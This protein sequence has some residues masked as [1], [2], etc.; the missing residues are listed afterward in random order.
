M[1]GS[2]ASSC[3]VRSS[4][5]SSP[6]TPRRA[7]SRI[8]IDAEVALAFEL[9]TGTRGHVGERRLDLGGGEA[10]ERVGI[11][12]GERV[13]IALAGIFRLEQPFVEPHLRGDGI[14]GGHPVD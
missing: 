2:A 14:G 10:L 12:V 11:E 1:L 3:S 8:G 5:T 7:G 6:R 13:A 9:V 4:P